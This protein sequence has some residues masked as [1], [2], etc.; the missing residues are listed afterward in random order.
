MDC[1]SD[2]DED[3]RYRK[4]LGM[5]INS[6]NRADDIKKRAQFN[7]VSLEMEWDTEGA[8]HVITEKF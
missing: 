5:D 3:K 7:D 1:D 6:T 8:L 4:T 2:S